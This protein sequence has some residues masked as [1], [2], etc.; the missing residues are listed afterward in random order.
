MGALDAAKLASTP[1]DPEDFISRLAGSTQSEESVAWCGRNAIIGFNDSGSLV[2]TMFPPNPSP[3]GSLSGDGWSA[4]VNAGGSFTDQG[5]LL[6]DPLP[7]GT[8]SL[9]LFGDPVTGCT[10]RAT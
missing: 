6:P 9:D 3:S 2:R 7:P 4:S 5:I 10:D 8:T 1:L